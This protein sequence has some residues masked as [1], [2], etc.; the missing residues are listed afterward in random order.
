MVKSQRKDDLNDGANGGDDDDGDHDHDD[1]PEEDVVEEESGGGRDPLD[2][3]DTLLI[4]SRHSPGE[5]V[6]PKG[7]IETSDSDPQAAALRETREETGACCTTG[8][9]LGHFTSPGGGDIRMFAV[10]FS[11]QLEDWPERTQ[12]Q[13]QWVTLRAALPLVKR[14]YLRDAIM[15]FRNIRRA[16]EKRMNRD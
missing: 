2:E 1:N 8:P 5:W 3:W 16:Y 11:S 4:T 13:F 7:E 9:F 10:F 14:P 12:R 6:H 15:T